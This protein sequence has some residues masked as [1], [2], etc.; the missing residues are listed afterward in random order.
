MFIGNA[1]RF[2]EDFMLVSCFVSSNTTQT[3]DKH[4]L[5]DKVLLPELLFQ[6]KEKQKKG[7]N[8]FLKL[9]ETMF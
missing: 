5:Y 8:S 2:F 7:Y 3:F 9:K 1:I 6:R 4:L